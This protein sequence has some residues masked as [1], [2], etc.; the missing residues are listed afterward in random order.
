MSP[1]P[2][3]DATEPETEG[4]E[5][6]VEGVAATESEAGDDGAALAEAQDRIAALEAETAKL[7]DQALRALA[8]T[9][10]IR[11]RSEREREDTAK[12]AI[13]SF[14]KSLLDAADNMRRAI[15]AVPA[16]AVEQDQALATLMD[17]VAAT[18]RQLLAAF[19]RNGVTRIEPVGEVFDPNFHQAMF[20]L[21]GS[22]KPAGTI[23]QVIQPGYVL[24]GRLLRPAMVGVAKGE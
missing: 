23:I 19:E 8:E 14:A 1:E 15:D 12:F 18:E 24:Q 21:P 9:E 2:R 6:A 4:L 11:R 20:E 22:G 7:K 16:E 5:P 13:S 17:G 10:N 3:P